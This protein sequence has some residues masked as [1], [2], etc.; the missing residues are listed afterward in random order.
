[1]LYRKEGQRAARAVVTLTIGDFYSEMGE[2][3][4]PF[5][6]NYAARCGANFVVLDQKRVTEHFGLDAKYEKFQ[7]HGLLDYYE[8]IAFID[9]DILITPNAPSLFELSPANQFAAASEALFSQAK[10]DIQL[11]QKVLG[12]VDWQNPYFNSGVMVFGRAHRAVFDPTTKQIM[13]WS[14]GSFRKQQVNL[15]NDQPYLNH[16]VNDL[17]IKL[18]DLGH[19]YNHTRVIKQTAT[20]FRS[21]FIHYAGASGH[22]YGSRLEQLSKDA[23]ILKSP[24]RFGL[25]RN[26]LPYRWIADRSDLAFVAYLRHERFAL[27]PREKSND[28]AKANATVPEVIDRS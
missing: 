22:R 16:R 27:R 19:R 4:H 15:L 18:F 17:G 5:M 14:T 11:T 13:V 8:H 6:K 3:T 20:R 7:L 1:M 9:T 24:W 23:R 28:V 26:L 12:P 21:F 25:S 10:R 2:I